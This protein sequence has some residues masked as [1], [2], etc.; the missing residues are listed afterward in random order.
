MSPAP[1]DSF[2]QR[3]QLTRVSKGLTQRALAAMV[4]TDQQQISLYELGEVRPR[5]RTM[6]NLAACLGVRREWLSDGQGPQYE[7]GTEFDNQLPKVIT[8]E[9]AKGETVVT[10]VLSSDLRRALAKRARTYGFTVD[11]LLATT[12][13]A[14]AD[15]SPQDG[16]GA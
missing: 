14:L 4:G 5:T 8:K 3:L 9:L 15:E 7:A 1:P 6:L 2:A 12:L 11:E 16:S 13:Y 10:F